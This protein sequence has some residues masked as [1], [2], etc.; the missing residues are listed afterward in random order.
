M[1]GTRVIF[2]LYIVVIVAGLTCA[3][4]LGVLGR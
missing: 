3:V 4:V 2:A 1:P